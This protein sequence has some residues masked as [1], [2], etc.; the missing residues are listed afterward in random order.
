[1]YKVYIPF[2][3]QGSESFNSLKARHCYG[4]TKK[5]EKMLNFKVNEQIIFYRNFNVGKILQI[6]YLLK[7]I[8]QIWVN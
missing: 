8:N 4:G 5:E 1:M 2:W 6:K 7:A 3:S